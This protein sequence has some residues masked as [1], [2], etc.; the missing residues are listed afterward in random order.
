MNSIN[1][2][3]QWAVNSEQWTVNSFQCDQNVKFEELLNE[4][5]NNNK[6]HVKTQQRIQK[7]CEKSVIF[8]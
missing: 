3:E 8:F 1:V 6:H 2:N 4:K 7:S 5:K